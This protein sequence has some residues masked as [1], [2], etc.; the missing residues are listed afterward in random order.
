VESKGIV[1]PSEYV[2]CI[3]KLDV[4]SGTMTDPLCCCIIY[5][6]SV[7][8]LLFFYFVQVEVLCVVTQ[9]SFVVGYYPFGGPNYLHIQGEAG[10]GR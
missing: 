8:Y 5:R 3:G 10:V 6:V 7:L 2:N 9:C 1:S 4:E